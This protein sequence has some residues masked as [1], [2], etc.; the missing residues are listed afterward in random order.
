MP[1]TQ[2]RKTPVYKNMIF[3]LYGTLIDIWTDESRPVLWKK[4][5]ELFSSVGAK[6]SG[7]ILHREY[8]RICAE[9]TEL[10]KK[11]TGRDY[12][13]IELRTVFARLLK[14]AP[15]TPHT[16]SGDALDKWVEAAANAFRFSS[17]KRFLVYPG[18]YETLSILKKSGTRLFMLSNAQAVFTRTEIALSGLG[19]CFEGIFL[20][21]DLGMR[22][23]EPQFMHLLLASFGLE[24]EETVMIGNDVTNDMKIADSCGVDSILLNTDG[25][26][27]DEIVRREKNCGIMRPER[28]KIIASG[29]ITE[30][31]ELCGV[32]IRK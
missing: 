30:L 19:E 20:S 31:P 12:P 3:D 7:P 15:G 8:L 2:G 28:I 5:A 18:T 6:Y 16:L 24:P 25:L 32:N 26:S 23:P 17:R 22:K 21:S 1:K 14:E 11:K 13:E 29:R 27:P 4:T 9:E 10:I